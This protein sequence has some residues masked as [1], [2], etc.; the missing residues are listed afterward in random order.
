MTTGLL[1]WVD[2]ESARGDVGA[3]FAFRS[4]R[5]HC[6]IDIHLRHHCQL[7]TEM[8]IHSHGHFK[9]IK[10]VANH[11]RYL[12]VAHLTLN[13]EMLGMGASWQD[14]SAHSMSTMKTWVMDGF[15]THFPWH[16]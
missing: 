4:R 1:C 10:S 12:H 6:I 9:S 16:G 7:A 3:R 8:Y 15:P 14:N 13:R 5:S 11:G 2:Q